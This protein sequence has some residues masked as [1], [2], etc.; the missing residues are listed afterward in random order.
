[1]LHFRLLICRRSL[2]PGNKPASSAHALHTGMEVTF[3]PWSTWFVR[4]ARRSSPS[5]PGTRRKKEQH[6]S[7]SACTHCTHFQV[8]VIERE[9]TN[10]AAAF[11]QSKILYMK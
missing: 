8:K 4:G 6:D 7:A 3:R 9:I 11:M 2:P 10:H 1:M 5:L